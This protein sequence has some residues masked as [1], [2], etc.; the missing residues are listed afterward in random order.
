MPSFVLLKQNTTDIFS[1]LTHLQTTTQDHAQIT[2][3][4]FTV[5]M[6]L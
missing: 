5:I 3:I 1:A 4:M 6:R 2:K